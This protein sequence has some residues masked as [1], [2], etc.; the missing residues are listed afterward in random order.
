MFTLSRYLVIFFISSISYFCLVFFVLFT[1]TKDLSHLL[2]MLVPFSLSTAY[3]YIYI[4][5]H[6]HIYIRYMNR[7]RTQQDSLFSYTRVKL[8]PTAFNHQ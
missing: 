8:Q 4:Y 3:I 1:H 6:T 2:K 5:T 7:K